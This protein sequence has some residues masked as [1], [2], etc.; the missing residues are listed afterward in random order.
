MKKYGLVTL[1]SLSF[2]SHATS[3]NT[4]SVDEYYK[5]AVE[6]TQKLD[7]AESDTAQS[8]FESTTTTITEIQKINNKFNAKQPP[9][10]EELQALQMEL[11]LVQAKIQADAL[12]LQSLAMIQEKNKKTKEEIHEEK[13]QEEHK[14]IAEKLKEE[15]EKS[16]VQ[17]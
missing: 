13:A 5:S 15:L 14:R 10:S 9:K 6:N 2:I 4:S 1:L 12:K 7:T 11:A 16:D 17:F 8:I 3:Q